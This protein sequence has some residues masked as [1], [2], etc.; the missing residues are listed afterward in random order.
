MSEQQPIRR[1]GITLGRR[2]SADEFYLDESKVIGENFPTNRSLHLI[3]E[4]VIP[5]PAGEV[6]V[7]IVVTEDVLLAT[8]QHVAQDTSRELGGFLLG[9]RYQCPNSG[10]PYLV[11]DQYM[12]AE[13]TEGTQVSLTFKAESWAQLKDRL[14]GKYRG[15]TLVGW[16]HSHPNMGIFLS[17]YD[18]EIH[19][20]RFSNE[21]DV[22]LVL[23]PV[24][25]EGGFFGWI[26]GRLNP[27]EKLD[28]YEM[29]DG[30]SRETVVAWEG[31]SAEDTKTGNLAPL[32]GVN[33]KTAESGVTSFAPSTPESNNPVS[34]NILNNPLV[35][36]GGIAASVLLLIAL[37]AV[38]FWLFRKPSSTDPSANNAEKTNYLEKVKTEISSGRVSVNGEV[39]VVIQN[40]G[41][42]GNDI[43]EDI[44]TN[45]NI[46]IEINDKAAPI[47]SINNVGGILEVRAKGG[48]ERDQVDSFTSDKEQPLKVRIDMAYSNDDKYAEII[49]TTFKK[50]KKTDEL[51][52]EMVFG[53]QRP[54][55]EKSK[56]KVNP[57]PPVAERREDTPREEEK[58]KPPPVIESEKPKI[59]PE[60]SAV[61]KKTPARRDS[62]SPASTKDTAID[63]GTPPSSVAKDAAKDAIDA[64]KK[65]DAAAKKADAAAKKAGKPTPTPPQRID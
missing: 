33:T 28:F 34:E 55:K 7:D 48:L 40:K 2:V 49:T 16:Y 29:L 62:E 15:K 30:N 24:K 27:R 3:P 36:F 50:G 14:E 43:I 44:S 35:L 60:K 12:K 52:T 25:H 65:A 18:V 61:A 5:H 11:I 10:K 47:V 13:Y 63:I 56:I 21:W 9:N 4:D 54:Q 31:Y 46:D 6:R 23:D 22:A 39:T 26:E 1:Q 42:G 37:V 64:A 41:I 53:N 45:N 51:G 8:S 17:N 20:N 19:K 57:K 38:G 58:P 59:I 32:K